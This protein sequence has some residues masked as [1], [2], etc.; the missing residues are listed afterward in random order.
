[1]DKIAAARRVALPCLAPRCC[2]MIQCI[3]REAGGDPASRIRTNGGSKS[4]RRGS[5]S[6][7]PCFEP[8]LKEEMKKSAVI[9]F[10]P[11]AVTTAALGASA[12]IFKGDGSSEDGK[13]VSAVS[14][15]KVGSITPNDLKQAMRRGLLEDCSVEIMKVLARDGHQVESIFLEEQRAISKNLSNLKSLVED[16]K[17]LKEISPAFEWAQSTTDIFLNVKFSHKLD[18][19]ATLDVQ[20]EVVIQEKTVVVRGQGGRKLF[21]LNLALHDEVLVEESSWTPA[22]VGR[23]TINLKKVSE[24][25]WP[26]LLAEGAKKPSKMHTWWSR[27]EELDGIEKSRK[28]AEEKKQ[29]EKE[30]REK[31]QREDEAEKQKAAVES[32]EDDAADSGKSSEEL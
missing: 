22:S 7:L 8:A 5:C 32:A 16:L 2:D 27:Q 9:C 11:L 6:G 31:K 25:R 26:S 20:P 18:A 1:M 23:L 17:P 15:S 29:K 4:S 24:S 3:A 30:E 14:R 19:P 28:E 21:A 12:S 13:C 10:V